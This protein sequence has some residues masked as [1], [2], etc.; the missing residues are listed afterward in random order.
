MIS[1]LVAL[2]FHCCV[3]AQDVRGSTVTAN[4]QAAHHN[5][6]LDYPPLYRSQ[7]LDLDLFGS[8]SLGEDTLEH[9][10]ESRFRHHSLWGGGGGLTYFFCRYVGVGG[11]FDAEGRSHQFVDSADGNVYVRVP[12]LETGVAPYIFG[13]GG[14]QFEDFHQSFGQAGGGVE[15][16]FCRHLG[17]FVD[18]RY[19]MAN[20]SEDYGEARAGFRFVF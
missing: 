13:G 7:E 12:I 11:E 5:D 2:P 18:G 15:Y 3:K 8:G 19:V 6:D 10:S 14:Y 4:A 9:L 16:R 1:V 17:I 20:K